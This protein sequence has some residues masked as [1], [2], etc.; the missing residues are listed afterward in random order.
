MRLGSDRLRIGEG[1]FIVAPNGG[2][3]AAGKRGGWVAGA[4]GGRARRFGMGPGLAVKAGR[5]FGKVGRRNQ[6]KLRRNPAAATMDVTAT[7]AG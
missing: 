1:E 3:R 5:V 7:V 4:G 2:V 6:K